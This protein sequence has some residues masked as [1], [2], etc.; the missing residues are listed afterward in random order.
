MMEKIVISIF[1]VLLLVFTTMPL[2]IVAESINDEDSPIWSDLVIV[3]R[4]KDTGGGV[5]GVIV[6]I[7]RYGIG[8]WFPRITDKNG[9]CEFPV[10]G[11]G[12]SYTVNISYRGYKDQ[13]QVTVNNDREYVFFDIDTS[14]SKSA[15]RN[16]LYTLFTELF[17]LLQK[18]LFMTRN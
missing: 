6:T 16:Y 12:Y 3:C 8:E 11:D 1:S 17:P 10:V 4:D 5:K 9:E 2:G 13:K 18:F 15:A 14:K 7:Y